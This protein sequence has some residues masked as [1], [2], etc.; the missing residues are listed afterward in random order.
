M[1]DI[2]NRFMI[3]SVTFLVAMLFTFCGT[4]VH[5]RIRYLS[6]LAAQANVLA[7]RSDHPSTAD[8]V[9]GPV[10]ALDSFR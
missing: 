10:P 8:R 6:Y 5:N 9:C 2:T 7:C 4:T 1:T 3:C